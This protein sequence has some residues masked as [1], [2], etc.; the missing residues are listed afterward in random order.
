MNCIYI[1]KSIY[2][3]TQEVHIIKVLDYIN[4]LLIVRYQYHVY[5][6]DY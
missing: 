4:E 1:F 6:S 3:Y 5:K 2:D